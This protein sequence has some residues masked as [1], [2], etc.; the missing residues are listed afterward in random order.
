MKIEEFLS[1]EEK[2]IAAFKAW[3][4]KM[5]KEDPVTYPLEMGSGD[6]DEQLHL[7]DTNDIESG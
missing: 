4:L 6:W 5:H 7:F 2:R 3:W 1:E